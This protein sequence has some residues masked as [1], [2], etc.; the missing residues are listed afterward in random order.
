ME[1]PMSVSASQTQHLEGIFGTDIVYLQQLQ[2]V[3]SNGKGGP[4][5]LTQDCVYV[6][7]AAS[8]MDG[9][10]EWEWVV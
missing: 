5:L 2:Q 7:R 10:F 3:I 4:Q 1:T 8:Q 6:N 9:K